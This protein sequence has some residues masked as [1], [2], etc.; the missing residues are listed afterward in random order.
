MFLWRLANNRRKGKRADGQAGA[1]GEQEI[2][3][4]A[5]EQTTGQV[6]RGDSDPLIQ[7]G[8][9][10][11]DL[12]QKIHHFTVLLLKIFQHCYVPFSIISSFANTAPPHLGP[13]LFSKGN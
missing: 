2:R 9:F 4:A 8:P 13:R 1:A 10:V 6:F 5:K 12:L 3:L 11:Q 7:G